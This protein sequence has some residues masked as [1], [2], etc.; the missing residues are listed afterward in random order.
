VLPQKAPEPLPALHTS[1][2]RPYGFLNMHSGYFKHVSHVENDVNE[3]GSDPETCPVDERR[4]RR[5]KHEEEKWDEEYY[6]Y[7]I[8][9]ELAAVH[10]AL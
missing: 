6:M 4:R 9:C 5:L 3:L 8:F 2:V 1:S 10:D 7:V